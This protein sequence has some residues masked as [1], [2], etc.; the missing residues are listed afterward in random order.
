MANA[1]L[2]D[3][4]S[5][6]LSLFWPTLLDW[7]LAPLRRANTII[8]TDANGR[9]RTGS[10]SRQEHRLECGWEQLL[11]D[12]DRERQADGQPFVIKRTMLGP[13]L[14]Y[15]QRLGAQRARTAFAQ[16]SQY[17]RSDAPYHFQWWMP[18][19]STMGWPLFQ[20]LTFG[21]STAASC[22]CS[23]SSWVVGRIASNTDASS[24][25]S[26]LR[27]RCSW[28]IFVLFSA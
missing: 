23:P 19:L 3:A 10:D 21:S 20:T 14:R 24:P 15:T 13:P 25:K 2:D 17:N 1:P 5:D 28:L 8:V 22:R 16:Y 12:H 7:N 26:V 4:D 18:L 6:L 11:G 9:Q 27:R